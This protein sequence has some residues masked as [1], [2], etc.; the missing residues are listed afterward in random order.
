ME[1]SNSSPIGSIVLSWGDSNP[2]E[3][4]TFWEITTP[5]EKFIGIGN[6]TLVG[7]MP[8]FMWISPDEQLVPNFQG[9][10]MRIYPLK[11]RPLLERKL[12][13]AVF[14]TKHLYL[15]RFHEDAWRKSNK[16]SLS[17]Y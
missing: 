4:V 15:P 17:A 14:V 12:A 9:Y 2:P 11:E 3:I 5:L 8:L 13:P 10:T 16:I 6:F 7:L 1:L